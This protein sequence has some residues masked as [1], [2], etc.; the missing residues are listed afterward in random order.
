MISY[1]ISLFYKLATT[2]LQCWSHHN[3][4]LFIPSCQTGNTQMQTAFC[5]SCILL[6]CR[7]VTHWE[8]KNDTTDL[9][10]CREVLNMAQ[11]CLYGFVWP[12]T[13]A[14]GHGADESEAAGAEKSLRDGF[15]N[16]CALDFW[17][18]VSVESVCHTNL[19]HDVNFYRTT[20]L[21]FCLRRHLACVLSGFLTSSSNCLWEVDVHGCV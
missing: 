15:Q 14:A 16:S 8:S 9:E 7:S 18:S 17:D 3:N 4:H 13:F 12:D 10:N 11:K 1:L 20:M 21:L 6:Y 2:H 5:R 19:S